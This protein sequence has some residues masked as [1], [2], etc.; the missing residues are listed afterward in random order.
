MQVRELEEGY[1]EQKRG[2][3]YNTYMGSLFNLAHLEGENCGKEK[4]IC[5]LCWA[6]SFKQQFV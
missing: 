2:E 5:P 6:A 1:R 3:L 4:T